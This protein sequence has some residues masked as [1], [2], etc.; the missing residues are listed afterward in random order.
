[1]NLEV[2]GKALYIVIN[3]YVRKPWNTRKYKKRT[4][5]D[6]EGKKRRIVNSSLDTRDHKKCCKEIK[7]C[8]PKKRKKKHQKPKTK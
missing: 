3:C 8:H 4:I 2:H 7:Q 5:K 1:L 6:E